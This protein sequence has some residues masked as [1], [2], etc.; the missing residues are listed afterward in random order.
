MES[1][2]EIRCSW[3]VPNGHSRSTGPRC[4]QRPLDPYFDRECRDAKRLTCRLEGAYA[5]ANRCAVAAAA[6]SS[7]ALIARGCQSR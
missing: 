4:R 7:A 6:T 2:S 3:S 1:F 5:A